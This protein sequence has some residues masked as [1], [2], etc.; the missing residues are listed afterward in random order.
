MIMFPNLVVVVAVV[1]VI[2][3]VVFVVDVANDHLKDPASF[4]RSS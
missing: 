1:V 3:F 4:K 2:V